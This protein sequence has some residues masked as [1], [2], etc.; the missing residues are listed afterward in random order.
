MKLESVDMARYYRQP[1]VA[2]VK[3]VSLYNVMKLVAV[4]SALLLLIYGR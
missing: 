3:T 1:Q 2:V 4:A